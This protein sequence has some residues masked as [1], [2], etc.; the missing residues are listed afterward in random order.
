MVRN[1]TIRIDDE[2]SK[3]MEKYSEV[4]WSQVSRE[5]IKKYIDSREVLK[6][7]DAAVKAHMTRN[8]QKEKE[9]DK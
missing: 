4:N 3:K 1:L 2:T 8:F 7:H 9:A 6:R 5:A